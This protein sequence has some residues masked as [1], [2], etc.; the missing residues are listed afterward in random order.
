[1][2]RQAHTPMSVR[3]RL[4]GFTLVELM[5]T[6]AIATFLLFGLVTIV[7]NIRATSGNQAQLAQL[8]DAQRLAVIMMTDVTQGAGYFPDPQ[9][10]SAGDLPITGVFAQAGQSV[11]GTQTATP[12]GDTL[13]IRYMT[14]GG[15]GVL[16]CQGTSNP[17]P[18][19]TTVI[20]TNNFYV[21]GNQQLVCDIGNGAPLP[22]VTGVTNLQV[23]Y[24]VKRNL[25]L[26]GNDADTYVTANS[27]A[28]A[29]WMYVT[30]VT[31]KVTFVNPLFGQKTSEGVVQQPTVSFTRV[32]DIMNR[33]GET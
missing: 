26:A 24:G 31:I 1:M 32:I 18:P 29:D 33:T 8:Q 2:N 22:L 13:W 17:N 27:M 10:Y 14:N 25:A 15:D 23:T 28:A 7:G 3:R 12:Q 5:V 16:N 30:S 9:T 21:N 19:G 4:Q 20:Y 6:V 11:F